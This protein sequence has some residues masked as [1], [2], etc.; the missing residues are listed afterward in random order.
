MVI[1]TH[2]L[3][4]IFGVAHRIIMLDKDNKGIIATG[5]PQLLK[6]ESM[7]EKVQHFFKRQPRVAPY[8]LEE[9]LD[10]FN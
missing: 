8:V 10:G 1:V 6:D 3:D 2:E 7:D 9:I 4:S 5:D